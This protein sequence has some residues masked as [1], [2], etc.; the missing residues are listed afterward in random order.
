[1]KL[2]I[3]IYIGI[4]VILLIVTVFAIVNVK[5]SMKYEVDEFTAM[6]KVTELVTQKAKDIKSLLLFL[7]TFLTYE[8]ITIGL[9]IWGLTKFKSN[10]Q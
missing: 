9:L 2:G 7:W 4:T 8:I 5:I 3:K 1:M 6:N 10:Q